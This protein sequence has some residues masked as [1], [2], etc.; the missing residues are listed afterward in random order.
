MSDH[1]IQP[2][3]RH[4]GTKEHHS[5]SWTFILSICGWSG[6]GKS[7][8]IERLIP[9]LNERNLK[10]AVLKHDA[11]Q[12]TVDDPRKDT[13]RFFEA[14]ASY[15]LAHDSRE[16]FIHFHKEPQ[17]SVHQ[18]IDSISYDVD[19][20]LIEGHKDSL[21]PKIWLEH[22]T[23]NELPDQVTHIVSKYQ[24][25]EDRVSPVM[26]FICESIAE[27]WS[28]RKIHAGI[29]IGGKSTRMGRPKHLIP[30]N[31]TNLPGHLIK[32]CESIDLPISLL[33]NNRIPNSDNLTY[34]PDVDDCEGPLAGM[35]SAM[36][37][38]PN[39]AWLFLACDMPYFDSEAMRWLLSHREPGVWAIIPTEPIGNNPL[40]ALYEPQFKS[41]LENQ[42]LSNDYCIKH[43]LTHPKVKH[44][45]IPE[46]LNQAWKNCNTPDEWQEIQK[47][48]D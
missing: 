9:I 40:G 45:Q 6:S 43:C 12:L 47:L 4:S 10:I 31:G 22:P 24:W 39:V 27:N 19:C 17:F 16:G 1:F 7:W 46:N 26:D 13:G 44:I 2:F 36:R 25:G 15:V 30:W 41:I 8:L 23:K 28:N 5:G 18:L 33:G 21:W 20:I 42:F 48:K 11:H 37:W 38:N 32:Q 35:L 3:V 14:D 29:L 34:I